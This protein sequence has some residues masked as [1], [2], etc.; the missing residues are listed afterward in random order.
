[1]TARAILT[2]APIEAETIHG[3]IAVEVGQ[4]D[5][6]IHGFISVP[7]ACPGEHLISLPDRL[8]SPAAARTLHGTARLAR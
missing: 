8:L 7:M 3:D 1:L 6:A 2:A 4:Y 5:A